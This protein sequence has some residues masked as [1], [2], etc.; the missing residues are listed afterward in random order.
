MLPFIKG[1]LTGMAFGWVL[2][3]VGASRYSRVI[4]MVTLRDT[5]IMKF[6]F[7]TIA[8]ASFIYGIASLLG[9]AEEFNLVPRVM[10]YTGPIHYI[11]GILF[12]ATMG[13]VGFCPGTCMAKVGGGG[14]DKKFTGFA[15][16]I[17]LFIG[18]LIYNIIKTPLTN[19]GLISAQAQ[20][21]TLH[22]LLGVSYGSLVMILGAICAIIAILVDRVSKERF[23]K[24]AREEKTLVDLIR[25]EWSWQVSGIAAGILIVAAT[26]QGGYLGFSGAILAVVGWAAH[27]VGMPIEAVP[28]LNDDIYWRAALIIGVLPGAYIAK[29]ISIPSL[30]Q[31]SKPIKK[32]FE[33]KA[34]IKYFIGG[35][36]ISLGA[37]L[38]GG[39][40][41][42]AFLAAWPTLSVGSFAM[43]LTFFAV[44]VATAQILYFTKVIDLDEAQNVGDR[45]YD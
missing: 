27:L 30:A 1:I 44:A 10:M 43:S 20:P 12:G 15:A 25:G 31:V 32:T 42:G 34:I 41:T 9:I 37:M 2:Y 39:C 21:L 26:W 16:T 22:G 13:F 8:T 5:K 38:G 4:G 35:T 33:V 23:Y 17:G 45:A 18:V 6:A 7:A 3:K 14:G 40:T 11:G 24:P 29:L 28:K 19:V 36:T